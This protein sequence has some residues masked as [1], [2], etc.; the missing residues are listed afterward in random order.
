MK[1]D[2]FVDLRQCLFLQQDKK[3]I[4]SHLHITVL[5]NIQCRKKVGLY[6]KVA[7]ELAFFNLGQAPSLNEV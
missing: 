2:V 7:V 5:Q 3:Q 4:P 6:E 1:T